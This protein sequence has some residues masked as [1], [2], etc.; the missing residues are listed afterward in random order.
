MEAVN[1]GKSW[2]SIVD[3]VGMLVRKEI[4]MAFKDLPPGK[5]GKSTINGA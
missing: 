4:V 1:F 2:R 3:Y 5:K